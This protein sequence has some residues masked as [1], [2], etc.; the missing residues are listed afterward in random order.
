MKKFAIHVR[1]WFR[2]QWIIFRHPKR[3]A[4]FVAA[5]K[6]MEPDLARAERTAAYRKLP[7]SDRRAMKLVAY[8]EMKKLAP[9]I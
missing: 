5:Y 3:F 8:R 9:R 2:A 1:H 4:N 7:R 6:E